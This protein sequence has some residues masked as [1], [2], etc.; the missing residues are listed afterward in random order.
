MVTLIV[1]SAIAM[2]VRP[3]VGSATTAFSDI[4]LVCLGEN[5]GVSQFC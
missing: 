3:M 4:G 1:V 5:F 2:E